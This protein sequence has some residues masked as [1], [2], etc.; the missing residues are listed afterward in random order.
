MRYQGRVRCLHINDIK[1]MRYQ[2]RGRCVAEQLNFGQIVQLYPEI[3][4][5]NFF[6]YNNSEW[7]NK[8]EE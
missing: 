5:N 1:F 8:F 2:G 7:R 4:L 3:L 6:F